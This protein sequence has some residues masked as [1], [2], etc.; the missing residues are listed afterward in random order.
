M[1]NDKQL[2][3]KVGDVLVLNDRFIQTVKCQ[4]LAWLILQIRPARNAHQRRAFKFI[5]LLN[6]SEEATWSTASNWHHAWEVIPGELNGKL[7]I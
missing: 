6:L 4:K 2:T 1:D 7:D 3:F 5:N